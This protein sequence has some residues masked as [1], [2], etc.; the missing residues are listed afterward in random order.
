MST[1]STVEFSTDPPSKFKSF[2]KM[3]HTL[4]I[5][6]FI[7]LASAL[8]TYILP[9]GEFDRVEDKETGNKVA[10]E[11]TFHSVDQNP[12]SIIEV[13]LAIVHGL[14]SASDVVFFIFIIGGVFQIINSTGTIEA[15]TARVGKTFM[16]RGLVVIPIFLTLFSIG[17]FTMGMSAEVM[18]FVPIGIA[19]ARSLGYD[20]VTGTAMV[21]LGAASGFTAGLLNPFNV[22]IAQSI[23]EIPLFSG[24]WLRAILLV[25][26][27]AVTSLYIMRY[28]KKVK[29][30]PSLGLAY[31][32]EQTEGKGKLDFMTS[33]PQLK[34]TH[35][36]TILAIVLGFGVLIWGVSQKGWWM[37]E[38]AAFFLSLGIIVGFLSRY[39]PSKIASE[40]VIGAK[41]ITFGAFIVGIAKGVVV[42][43]EQGAVIDS[44][45]NGLFTTIEHLPTQI[46]VM[47]I[48]I[49][50]NIMNVFIT[51]GTGQAA[52]TMPILVP[53]A[54][55]INV[56][57]QTTVLIFQLGDGLSNCILPT[58]AMLMGSLAV[59]RIKYQ[60]WVKFF[61]PLLFIWT[62]IGAVFVLI[63]DAIQY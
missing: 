48:Y 22:G 15:V 17:G 43:L 34:L 55:L 56:T 11:N 8:L 60:E 38:L 20:A 4:V 13:P 53:L 31:E 1:K 3:P 14:T 6:I 36:F 2:F 54:D 24:M 39:G 7:I 62:V 41:E 37:E 63:A 51:S 30:D 16:N 32:L 52:T 26:L 29:R 61:W 33:L 28:A 44:V 50:Q 21:M 40:F 47:G 46:Q 19:I 45:V 57:R 42:V 10:V 58:S 9:A 27:L 35:Y 25:V 18:A 59:S 23:A 12:V 5:I 49:V